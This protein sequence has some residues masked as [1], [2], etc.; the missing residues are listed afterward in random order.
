MLKHVLAIYP[1]SYFRQPQPIRQVSAYGAR[2]V[3]SLVSC[4]SPR[5][6]LLRFASQRCACTDRYLHV[7]RGQGHGNHISFSERTLP[8]VI[9]PTIRPSLDLFCI[10]VT[11]R[12]RRLARVCDR[13]D[14]FNF[15][16]L[17]FFVA[18]GS[19]LSVPVR[20]SS[21]TAVSDPPSLA[22]TLERDPSDMRDTD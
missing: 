9:S 1:R 14:L 20:K 16:K 10:E 7:W 21:Y 15:S 4:M 6:R 13:I 22:R 19:D 18:L 12:M 5:R 17:T 8:L 11:V 3:A 2:S